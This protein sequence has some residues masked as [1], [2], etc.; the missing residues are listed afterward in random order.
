MS[1]HPIPFRRAVVAAGLLLVPVLAACSAGEADGTNTGTGTPVSGGELTYLV[2]QTQLT[3]D[4]AVSPATVTG[5]VTRPIFD[6]LV[7]QTSPTTFGPWLATKWEISADG[8]DYT[9]HLK[10]GITFTDGTPFDAAAVKATLDHVVDPASKSQYAASLIAPYE[11]TT[12]VDDLTAKVRLSKP[13]RP[14]LQALSTPYLGIQSPKALRVPAAD[15]KP[16][17]TGPFSFVSWEQQK[18]IT[19]TRNPAYAAAPAGAPH[20][21]PAYLQTLKFGYVA[22][23]TTRYGALTSGQA[24]AIAAVPSGRVDSLQ[25]G[26]KFRVLKNELPGTGYNLY[27]NVR[28]GPTSD[29]SVREAVQRAI[30]VPALVANIYSGQYAPAKNVLSPT[31]PGYDRAAEGSL[32]QFDPAK[33]AE[34]LDRAGWTGRNAE[35]YRTKDGRELTLTW[36]YLGLI[37]RDRRDVLGQAIQAEA[38]KA[39]IRIDRPNLDAGAYTDLVLNGGYQ[40]LDTGNVR[41]DADILRFSFGSQA[42][43]ARGGANLSLA[44]SPELDGW[45]DEAA[46]TADPA[47]ATRDYAQAQAYVLKNGYVL[48]GYVQT[49]LVGTTAKLSGLTVDAQGIARFAG[50]WLAK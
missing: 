49:S 33:A 25:A 47:V 30:D 23:E 39:G 3:L 24:Q 46:G 26:G 8:R 50:A 35:G 43:F 9:F 42:T 1:A 40:I 5:L 36:P 17:G 22:E 37:N 41:A 15:Y 27:F 13:F 6:S 28:T 11:S 16:V 29:P 34:L 20:P 38:K 14:F 10:R 2:D 32:P 31:T 48:P 45:L 21:G 18:D 44:A 4:P 19:L 12:I 7:E